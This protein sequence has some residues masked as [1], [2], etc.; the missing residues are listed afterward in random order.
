MPDYL[1]SSFATIRSICDLA[2]LIEV[3]LKVAKIFIYYVDRE[4]QEALGVNSRDRATEVCEKFTSVFEMTC[5]AGS[6]DMSLCTSVPMLKLALC[7]HF[8]KMASHLVMNLF[9]LYVYNFG[10]VTFLFL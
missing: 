10:S 1:K 4:L 6:I 5:F 8:H 2:S 3:V 9:Y 7:L